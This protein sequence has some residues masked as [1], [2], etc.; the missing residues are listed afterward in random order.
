MF[1]PILSAFVKLLFLN[2]AIVSVFLSGSIT[3]Q[4]TE[5]AVT[6][7]VREP[8]VREQ[9]FDRVWN[10]VNDR[11]FDPTFGGL[12]W[13]AIGN[14]YRPIALRAGSLDDFHNVLRQMLGE[15]KLSHFAI[16]PREA[17]DRAGQDSSTTVGI[18]IKYLRE[19]AVVFRV[20]KDSPAFK[21]GIRPG[22]VIS[23]VD[24]KTVGEL[25]A[26]LEKALAARSQTSAQEALSR[27]RMLS[28][29]VGGPEGTSVALELI[30]PG[31]KLVS[32]ELKREAYQGEMS[33]PFG[34]FPPQQVIFTSDIFPGNIGY[35]RFNIWV[36]PQMQKLRAAVREMKAVDGMVI[37]LRGNPGGVGA[38]A[39][40]LAG[41]LYD[42]Q[43]SLGT[44]RSRGGELNFTVFPQN[45]PFLGPVIILTDHGTGSTSEVFAAG[46][47]EIGR[48]SVVGTTTAGAV[49]PS[50]FDILPTGA[51]FQFAVSDY[52]SPKNVLIEGRGVFPD[53]S[54]ELDLERLAKGRDSQLEEAIRIINSNKGK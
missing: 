10:T 53:V 9:A 51:T 32:A 13:V 11:H 8:S 24:G 49:L 15:L 7:E 47:Q 12:D 19:K 50:V 43:T 52:R 37:D 40:G 44:M 48:A 35:I 27:E 20:G 23:R 29:V 1:M 41:L 16:F 34:N 17:L 5:V 36:I 38:M 4:T 6:E 54:A 30:V 28:S 42:K 31:G 22:D 14:K 2:L 21:A 33:Q 46:M 39:S 45:D 18:E 25:L 3:A 26:P